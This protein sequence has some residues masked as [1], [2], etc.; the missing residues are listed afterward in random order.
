MLLAVG[1]LIISIMACEQRASGEASASHSLKPCA[2]QEHTQGLADGAD[3]RDGERVAIETCK[4]CLVLC[5]CMFVFRK[6]KEVFWRDEKSQEILNMTYSL[7]KW[8]LINKR[9]SI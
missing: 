6:K 1:I 4:G 5:F 3:V 7:L 8:L 2:D 9:S